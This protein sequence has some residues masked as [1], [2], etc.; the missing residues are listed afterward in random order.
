M[1]KHALT[2]WD[3]S[4]L[5]CLSTDD[6]VT[7]QPMKSVVLSAFLSQANH[8]TYVPQRREPA[9]IPGNG[10]FENYEAPS[11]QVKV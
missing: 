11:V 8:Q 1:E 9:I 6:S 3:P 4:D 7:H 5:V 10:G 2:A